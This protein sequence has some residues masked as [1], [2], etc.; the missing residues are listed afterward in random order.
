[1]ACNHRFSSLITIDPITTGSQNLHFFPWLYLYFF[2]YQKYSPKPPLNHYLALWKA[3]NTSISPYPN[4]WMTNKPPYKTP[5]LM[6]LMQLLKAWNTVAL[7]ATCG[8]G[9]QMT[10]KHR[11]RNVWSVQTASRASITIRR[12]S[13][14]KITWISVSTSTQAWTIW[15]KQTCLTDTFSRRRGEETGGN[16]VNGHEWNLPDLNQGLCAHCHF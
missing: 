12:V 2:D 5:M 10:A 16:I 11:R 13:Q 6:R 14:P 15:S 4:L 9:S 3:M 8:D 1:M 7:S